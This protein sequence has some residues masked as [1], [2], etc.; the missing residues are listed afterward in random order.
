MRIRL[1][2]GHWLDRLGLRRLLRW[3]RAGTLC[4]ADV[5]PER[6]VERRPPVVEDR[7]SSASAI[8][9]SHAATV[10]IMIVK[11]WPVK[12]P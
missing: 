9:A 7:R 5:L 10:R 3:R 8:D 6:H 12:L 2:A 4:F 1:G 11:T